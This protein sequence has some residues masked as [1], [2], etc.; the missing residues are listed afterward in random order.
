M[1]VP[2]L[3][4]VDLL[5]NISSVAGRVRGR[6]EASRDDVGLERLGAGGAMGQLET[7]LAGVVV[8][9]LKEVFDRDSSRLELEREQLRAERERAERAL[10]LEMLRQA[11]EREMG[12]LRLMT[13]VAVTGWLA[14][15]LVA[16]RV[17][18]GP[19][20]ARALLAAGWVLLLMAMALAFSA[21]RGLAERL[22]RISESGGP[23]VRVESGGAAAA[24]PWMIVA[25]FGLVG[26][27]LLL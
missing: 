17:A 25:G 23:T 24:I 5:V 13:T 15:L 4:I 12:R 10:R 19:A 20:V 18:G 22:D 27:S 9:A 6:S 3:R 16:V 26:L 2:W 11:G 7:R 21:Q 14:T 1:A 8:A